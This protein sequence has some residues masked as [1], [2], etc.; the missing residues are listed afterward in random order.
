MKVLISTYQTIEL[1]YTHDI[2]YIEALENYCRITF[3]DGKTVISTQSFGT[4]TRQLF[5]SGFYQ[6]HKSYAFNL[7]YLTRYYKTGTIELVNGKKI[8]VARRRKDEFLTTLK[9][10][11]KQTKNYSSNH[12]HFMNN[13][14]QSAS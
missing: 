2:V 3:L 1:C 11:C 8:P 9:E 12:E 14:M 6:C 13:I 10:W 5:D 4:F 7:K